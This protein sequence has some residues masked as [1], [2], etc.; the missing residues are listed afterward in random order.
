MQFLQGFLITA[1]DISFGNSM[2][3]TGNTMTNS[4]LGDID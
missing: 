3:T 1:F 4:F 2:P